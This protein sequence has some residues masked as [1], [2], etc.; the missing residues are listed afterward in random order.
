MKLR[1]L[2]FALSLAAVLG[3]A[4]GVAAAAPTITLKSAGKL[5]NANGATG[6]VQFTVTGGTPAGK[7]TVET[8][9]APVE[10][11]AWLVLADGYLSRTATFNRNG[12]AQG[13]VKYRVLKNAAALPREATL[14]LQASGA[15]ES[16]GFTVSQKAA[17]C[18]VAIAPAEST[19]PAAGGAGS[20]QVTAPEGCGWVA[21]LGAG[22]RWVGIV[23]GRVGVGTATVAFSGGANET[24]A[25]RAARIR[26]SPM[27]GEPKNH[28]VTQESLVG[29]R[30][31]G[32][33]ANRVS[34]TDPVEETVVFT[35][36]GQFFEH[37]RT[38]AGAEG[39][40]SAVYTLALDRLTAAVRSTWGQASLAA[41]DELQAEVE[42][43]AGA[44]CLR[45]PTVNGVA[46]AAD[47]GCFGPVAR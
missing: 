22:V 42:L 41:G 44:L 20:F 36:D 16:L 38:D 45:N 2:T 21:S 34:G 1:S 5:F 25:A 10:D 23:S 32:I 46:L 11:A 8:T 9:V 4:G 35:Q 6:V 12:V 47:L 29:D 33:W 3:L 15:P 7:V 18:A 31:I 13:Q 37:R 40:F 26:V 27:G 28:T 43:Q 17:P 19:L 39:S 14:L 24:G 30:A